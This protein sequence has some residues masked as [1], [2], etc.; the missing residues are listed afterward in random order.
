MSDQGRRSSTRV[1]MH[2]GGDIEVLAGGGAVHV[3]TSDDDGKEPATPERENPKPPWVAHL[4]HDD[5]ELATI[6]L[7]E[8]D[9]EHLLDEALERHADADAVE[10]EPSARSRVEIGELRGVMRAAH[11]RQIPVDIR[12]ED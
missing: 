1:R 7:P 3:P 10:I 8:G 6:E 12:L 9:Q 4:V 5:E 2:P 11:R